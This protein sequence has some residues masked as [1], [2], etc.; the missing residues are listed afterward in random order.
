MIYRSHI[1][2]TQ[3]SGLILFYMN[4]IRLDPMTPV[5]SL[6]S[7]LLFIIWIKLW[8]TYIYYYKMVV[9]NNVA[10]VAYITQCLTKIYILWFLFLT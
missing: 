6:H 5:F 2:P 4:K 1:T 3:W 9:Y 10:F 8:Y 7:K